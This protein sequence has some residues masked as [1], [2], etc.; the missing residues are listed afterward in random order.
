M[1]VLL[2]TQNIKAES[3]AF[4][5]AAERSGSPGNG[6]VGDCGQMLSLVETKQ[7]YPSVSPKHIFPK[8]SFLK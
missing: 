5:T 2:F 6:K 7:K 8:F 1:K 3:H 4:Q